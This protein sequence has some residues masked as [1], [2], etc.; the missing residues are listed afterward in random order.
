MH[1]GVERSAYRVVQEALTDVIKHAGATT[2]V[3]VSVRHLPDA[4]AVSIDDDGRGM[5]TWHARG[6]DSDPAAGHGPTGGGHGL[7]GMRERVEL[8]GGE[9]SVGGAPG[10]GRRVAAFLPHGDCA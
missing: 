1:P 6:A 3:E 5:T 2:R 8:W 4:L 9:L 10:G 7:I